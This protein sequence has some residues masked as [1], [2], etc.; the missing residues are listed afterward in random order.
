ME[1]NKKGDKKAKGA[2][3]KKEAPKVPPTQYELL[4]Q[5]GVPE[6]DIPKF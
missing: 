3:L 1:E 4:M 5:I 6:A 2:D